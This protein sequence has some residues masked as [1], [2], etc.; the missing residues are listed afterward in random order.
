MSKKILLIPAALLLLSGCSGGNSGERPG[1]KAHEEWLASLNDSIECLRGEIDSTNMQLASLR[2]EML[3]RVKDFDH[4]DNPRYV[5]GFT[6]YRGW[7]GRYPLSTTGVVARMTESEAFELVAANTGV[8]FTRITAV[9]PDGKSVTTSTV[10]YDKALNY[11]DGNLNTV[12]FSDT[13]ADSVGMAIAESAGPVRIIY[14]GG[15]KTA[16]RQLTAA[17]QEMISATWQL[18]SLNRKTK[19][20]ERKLPL[21]QEKIKIFQQ[22]A[23][24]ER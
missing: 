17:E 7:S 20:L 5:E 11:R 2:E 8:T 10:P 4:V 16:S 14:E 22:K 3:E 21:L 13:R 1:A 15:G 6:I 24:Q 9:M 18:I 12:A 23:P 19:D